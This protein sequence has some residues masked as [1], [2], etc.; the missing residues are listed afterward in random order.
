M[1]SRHR[2]PLNLTDPETQ[3]DEPIVAPTPEA[4]AQVGSRARMIAESL[5][6]GIWVHRDRNQDLSKK[7]E[8]PHV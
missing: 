4:T 3:E 5:L 8:L 6:T 2:P 1:K 7:V